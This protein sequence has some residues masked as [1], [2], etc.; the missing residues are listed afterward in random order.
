MMKKA[1][2][3]ITGSLVCLILIAVVLVKYKASLRNENN[4]VYA[5]L[6]RKGAA[7][8]TEEWKNTRLRA[9]S[10]LRNIAADPA[11]KKSLIS[12]AQ[13]YVQEGRITGNYA[14][15][16]KAALKYAKDAL[17]LEPDNFEASVTE[18]VIYLSQ[19]HFADG[20]ATAKKILIKNPYSSYVYGLIVDGNVEMGYY[21]S[22]VNSAERMIDIRPDLRSYSRVS[23]LREIYGDNAGAI[24]A[25]KLAVDAGPPG[26]ETTEW[27]RIQLGH[28]YE[29]TGDLQ[30]AKMQYTIAL[31]ERRGYA[32]ALAG[33]AR[34]AV[35][36]KDYR[37]AV[38]LYTEANAQVTDF[39]IQEGLSDA[40]RLAGQPD[41]AAALENSI[42]NEMNKEALSGNTDENI[43]H[44]VDRELAYAYLN[45]HEY[46]KALEHA[47]LEYNRRPNNIDVNEAVAWVYYNRGEYDKAIPYLKTALKTNSKN[48][49]LLHRAQLIE[50]KAELA[51]NN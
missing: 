43:G 25:M 15:Y 20:L 8:T 23:Y 40:Y 47:L 51:K 11:D 22:A 34:L 33:L 48:P 50:S 41:K 10:L 46:N 7:A 1:T 45:I 13:L 24:E 3:Y 6:P 16:D 32:Y 29:N 2:L 27:A 30:N 35:A 31:N 19:H 28:L 5:L 36:Q 37:T 39:S 49:T 14:Y 42:I 21:D 4:S 17:K 9:A 26:D 38:K 18:S 12:L 44:Y